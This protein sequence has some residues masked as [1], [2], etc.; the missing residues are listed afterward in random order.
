MR[1]VGMHKIFGNKYDVTYVDRKGH[2]LFRVKM[3]RL[4]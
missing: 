3:V 4:V 1:E 2:I